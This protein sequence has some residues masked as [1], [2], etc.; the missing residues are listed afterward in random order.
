MLGEEHP[1][2]VPDLQQVGEPLT[3]H[4]HQSEF[5]QAHTHTHLPLGPV[6]RLEEGSNGVNGG[7]LVRVRL[8]PDPGVVG[9]A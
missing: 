7:E 1:I 3:L 6:R 8:H 4:Y 5:T 9:D 2:H